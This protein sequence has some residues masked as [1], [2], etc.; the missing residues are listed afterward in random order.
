MPF[1]FEKLLVYQKSVEICKSISRLT[2]TFP[3][4]CFYLTDQLNRAA[5]SISLNIAE[6][7]GRWHT[8]D[9]KQFFVIAR[10]SVHECVP[11]L[12]VCL[13][14]Q[15]INTENHQT[16]K[17]ELEEISRMISGMIKGLKERE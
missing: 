11:I 16:L 13:S 12:D 10:G 3:R 9:R 6:G 2:D 14:K 4:G 7:N 1:L 15:L 17:V 5:L 8:N